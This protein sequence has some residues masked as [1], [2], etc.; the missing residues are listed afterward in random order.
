[1]HDKNLKAPE[2]SDVATDLALEPKADIDAISEAI[3][4]RYEAMSGDTEPD[5]GPPAARAE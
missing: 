3:A 4:A 2:L 5:A 1:M